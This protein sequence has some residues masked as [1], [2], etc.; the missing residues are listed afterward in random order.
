VAARVAKLVMLGAFETPIFGTGRS[1]GSAMVPVEERKMV[2][3]YRL[4]IVTISLYLTIRPQFTIEGLRRSLA[5][6]KGWVTLEQNLGRKGLADV[7]QILT[8]SGREYE[9]VACKTVV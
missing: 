8:R 2:V 3:S 1:L 5:H 7:S 9:A 6:N 4:S